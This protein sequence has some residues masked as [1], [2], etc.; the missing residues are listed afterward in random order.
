MLT[1]VVQPGDTLYLIARRFG[2]SVEALMQA[3]NLASS[4]LIPG[5]RLT[6]PVTVPFTYEVQPGDTLYLIARRFDTTV[7]AVMELNRLTSSSLAVGQRLVIPVYTEAIVTVDSANVRSR[8]GTGFPIVAQMARGARLPVTGIQGDWV[9][10]RLFNANPGWVF[11]DIVDL[12]PH[13]GERPI[14]EIF[15]YYVEEEGPAL[16]SSREV[17]EAQADQLTNTAMF[18]FRIDRENP[19]RV[20]KFPEFDDEYMR[21]VIGYGHRHNVKMLACIHNLLYERGNQEVNQEVIGVM[22]ATMENRSAFIANMLTVLR[23]YNFDGVNIDFED[24]RYEDRELL[25]AL[26]RELEP[27]LRDAGYYYSVAVPSRTSD[28]PTNPFSAPFTY[29]VIGG[30]VDEFVVMLY[31]E[32]G[33]P[34][35]GPGPVVS[36]GWMESVVRYALTKMPGRKITAAVSVFGFDF[37]LT[38]GRNTYATYAMA[39]DLARRYNRTVIFD[40]ETQTPMF[41][42]TD[43]EGNDHEVWFEN[44]ASIRAKLLLAERLG[45]RGVALWRLGMEDPEMWTMISE[46]FVVEKAII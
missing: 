33:W 16:P 15:G 10:I 3:N 36:I 27:Q 38:T 37:N 18:H 25:N 28:E 1:Y 39:M 23:S 40:E 41:A 31:N 22:L 14:T 26:Y 46:E 43:E 4:A 29:A 17:F 5:Q 32:H 42:Y 12:V 11:R 34:G 44:A 7:E 30:V 24:V 9:R 19:S 45:I 8:P 2:T 13:S 6:I 20:E 21:E 35:S